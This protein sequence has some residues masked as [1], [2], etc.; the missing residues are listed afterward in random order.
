V[1]ARCSAAPAIQASAGTPPLAADSFDAALAVNTVHHWTDLEMGLAELGR[2]ARRRVV[3]VLRDPREGTRFWLVDYVP[4]LD[5]SEKMARIVATI[6]RVFPPLR[7]DPLP[8]PAD[9]SDGVFSAFWARPEMYL[10]ETVRQNMSN[11]ALADGGDVEAGLGQLRDD[12][13]SGEWDR[14]YGRL[15]SLPALDPGYRILTAELSVSG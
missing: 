4:A 15:R 6:E 8:L 14:R 10:D 12:L 9:C 7:S 1:T 3:V 5:W 11:F 2:V 13:G